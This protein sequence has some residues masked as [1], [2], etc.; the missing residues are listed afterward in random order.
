MGVH[1]SNAG[2]GQHRSEPI[3]PVLH[4]RVPNMVNPSTIY[5]VIMTGLPR[6]RTNCRDSAEDRRLF[7]AGCASP[8]AIACA[9]FFLRRRL[10]LPPLDSVPG[11]CRPAAGF[12]FSTSECLVRSASS[13][14]S[15]Y[16]ARS[17][18]SAVVLTASPSFRSSNVCSLPDSINSVRSIRL[19][20]SFL[21]QE[22][23][24]PTSDIVLL[25][26]CKR[27]APSSPQ[28]ACALGLLAELPTDEGVRSRIGDGVTL[29][30]GRRVLPVAIL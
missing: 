25:L 21:D 15:W 1:I 11:R 20:R 22:I 12:Q 4:T 23:K 7:E 27:A 6:N 2:R 19:A 26:L 10:R 17:M 28:R 14:I 5:E 29:I 30:P 3:A 24:S 18:D 9:P 13:S 16:L 8:C